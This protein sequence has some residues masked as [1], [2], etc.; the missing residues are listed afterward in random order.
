MFFVSETESI[1]RLVILKFYAVFSLPCKLS[2]FFQ[3]FNYHPSFYIYIQLILC[4]FE[5]RLRDFKNNIIIFKRFFT[6]KFMKRF[7]NLVMQDCIPGE[8]KIKNSFF[9]LLHNLQN[10][11]KDSMT[12]IFQGMERLWFRLMEIF[13][14]SIRSN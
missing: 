10:Q 13:K 5:T 14:R 7:I 2:P 9:R 1:N 4:Y 3:F 6:R 11:R 12:I 8:W